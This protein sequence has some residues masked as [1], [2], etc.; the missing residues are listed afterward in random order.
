[1]IL[2]RQYKQTVAGRGGDTAPNYRV[3]GCS[4]GN[5]L[6][7]LRLTNTFHVSDLFLCQIPIIFV[8]NCRYTEYQSGPTV[9]W[10]MD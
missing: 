5:V 4:V 9:F 3:L 6:L 10:N 1:M 7:E 8:L 2:Y